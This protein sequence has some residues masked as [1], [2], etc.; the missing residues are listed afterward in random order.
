[1]R[2]SFE[3][4]TQ[5]NVRHRD[6]VNAAT[7]EEAFALLKSRG[8]KPFGLKEEPNAVDRIGRFFRRGWVLFVI[9]ASLAVVTVAVT[10]SGRRLLV[11][12]SAQL[13]SPRHQIY[14]DPALLEEIVRTDF[15]QL[16]AHPGERFLARYAEPGVY[17]FRGNAES[18]NL[19]E[20]AVALRGCLEA[21]IPSV[22]GEEREIA[23]YKAIVRG[24]KLELKE[25]LSDGVGT[26]DGYLRRLKERLST[27]RQIR[28]R[29]LAELAADASVESVRRANETLRA[30]GLRTIPV[31]MQD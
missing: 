21:T 11:S 28:A 5:D 9:G 13:V 24:M 23:E 20:I 15:A 3:Y 14:G 27:E 4:R 31:Q 19:N 12:S 25:Y 22:A 29:V 10:V 18:E 26:A 8:V 6:V 1:M 30:Y 17:R 16:F 7:R 2:F